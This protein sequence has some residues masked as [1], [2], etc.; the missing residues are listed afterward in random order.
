MDGGGIFR[1]STVW[2]IVHVQDENDNTPEFKESV[3]RISL[4]GGTVTNAVILSTEPS[5]TIEMKGPMQISH[6]ASWM[7]MTTPNS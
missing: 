6:T 4:P 1:Q 7:E 2:V 5:L 3:Y